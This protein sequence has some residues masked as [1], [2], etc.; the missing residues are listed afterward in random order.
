V[1]SHQVTYQGPSALAVQVATLL[2][3]ADG[4]DL[5]SAAKQ[6]DPGGSA[7]T[8]LVLDLEGS[9]EAV[10]AAVGSIQAQLPAD[11][12]ITVDDPVPGQ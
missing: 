4:I 2:A 12:R 10:T 3:D 5:T 11:A 7:E 9:T 6:D 1:T 8:V